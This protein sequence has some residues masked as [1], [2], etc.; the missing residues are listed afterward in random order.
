MTAQNTNYLEEN[1]DGETHDIEPRD[2]ISEVE[3]RLYELF[4]PHYD[5]SR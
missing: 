5:E 1:Y 2:Q 3:K 4:G